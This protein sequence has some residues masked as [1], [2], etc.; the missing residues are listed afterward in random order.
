MTKQE[1]LQKLN[2]LKKESDQLVSRSKESN[3]LDE[4]TV[5][6][7][8]LE[9]I[10]IRKRDLESEYFQQDDGIA[11]RTRV[12]NE[13][14]EMEVRGDELSYIPGTG[15]GGNTGAGFKSI[16]SS[17]LDKR[18]APTG[19]KDNMRTLELRSKDSY[20]E[21]I[22]GTIANEE[23]GLDLGKYIK[24]AVTGDFSNAEAEKRAMSTTATGVLIPKELSAK[25]IDLARGVSLFTVA[26]VPVIPMKSNNETIARVK[27]NP[28]FKFKQE[29]GKADPS[30][31]ELEPIELKAKTAYGY[32]YVSLEAIESSRNL[33]DVIYNAFSQAI[34]DCIDKGIMYGQYNGSSY[35]EF[36]PKGILNDE[37]I[38]TI[39]ATAGAGYDDFIK[40]IGKVKQS[41][42]VPSVYGINSHTDELLSLLK[43]SDGQYLEAPKAIKDMKQII[44]NELQHE[45]GGNDAL[46]FD[47]NAIM[48]GIQSGIKIEMFTNTDYCIEHGAVGFK[49]CTML[50]AVT[51]QPK[52]I[53]K[54]TGIK[55]SAG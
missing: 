49:V 15:F 18:N 28:I 32:A 29:L 54:I 26:D 55:E 43:T 19:N 48:I 53:C 21:R 12:I 40:A 42:G 17:V 20:L 33:S 22:V 36:A 47:P 30:E 38:H 25:I 1:Y 3:D 2:N 41:N 44:S 34:A 9:N 52:H 50:D 13:H 16:E 45:D 24:G 11:E 37:A 27:N 39:T 5:I 10:N 6:N 46:V 4:L 35:D 8:K 51:V 31:F 23:R 7:V 14:E